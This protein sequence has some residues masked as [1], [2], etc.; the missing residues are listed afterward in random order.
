MEREVGG[1]IASVME[2]AIR[3]ELVLGTRGR[4]GE[5]FDIWQAV[6]SPVGEDGY[7][8]QILNPHTGMINHKV[9]DYWKEHY[10]LV[11]V[12]QRDWKTLGP[13]LV[14]KLH[15]AVGD[16]DNFYLD[17]AV[18]LAEKFL[19]STKDPGRGPYYGGS[20]EYGAG[21]GHGYSG[22]PPGP[23]SSGTVQQRLM[24]QMLQQMLKTAPA[25]ADVK[26]WR[27]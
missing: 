20:F 12:M 6:Y 17:R 10:D 13:Q 7:P 26:S 14:G 15:F 16:S 22:G 9:A 18:R 4:S 21:A 23:E 11:H 3:Y 25:G 19:E 27:Y 24:P 5:Q 2:D 8:D 1:R